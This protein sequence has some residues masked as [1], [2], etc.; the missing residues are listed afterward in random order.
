MATT[1]LNNPFDA[2]PPAT[3]A[4]APVAS[5]NQGLVTNAINNSVAGAS[6]AMPP[7]PQVQ[8]YTPQTSQVDRATETAAGQVDSLLSRDNPLLQRAR[9]I[10]RQNMAQRGLV[11]SSMAQGAGVAAMIDRITPIAQQDALTFSNR[12]MTN[13]EAINQAGLFNAGEAN[14]FSLQRSDQQFTAGQNQAQRDFNSAQAELD[15]AQQVALADKSITAQQALQTAQQNFQAAQAALDRTQQ[16]T[17]QTAQQNFAAAQAALDRAQQIS[18]ADKSIAAN[19]ALQQAQQEF[20]R[21]Q[22]ELDRTLQTNLADKN[23]AAQQ[24]QLQN[25]QTFAAS[26]AALDRQQQTSLQ[27]S[28]V[29]AN[30]ASQAAS[31]AFQASQTSLEIASRNSANASAFISRTIDQ[32]N[33]GINAIIAD[34]NLTPDAKKVAIQNIVD[35]TN[36]SLK[37][38]ATFYNTTVPGYTAPGGAASVLNPGAGAGGGNADTKIR[39]AGAATRQEIAALY[40]EVFGRD[41]DASGANFWYDSGYTPAQIRQAF[42]QSDEYRSKQQGSTGSSSNSTSNNTS[43][44]GTGSNSSTSNNTSTSSTSS[45]TSTSNAGSTGT[46]STTGTSSSQT[47]S[48]AQVASAIQQSMAQGFTLEQSVNAATS[49]YGVPADQAARVADSLQAP[50]NGGGIIGSRIDRDFDSMVER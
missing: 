31:Q 42:L 12:T 47:Y 48:D 1:V 20:Q 37:W 46:A 4:P 11:N 17:L 26:Q 24:A 2:N 5:P 16:V 23:L 27:Q 19:Q 13:M 18:L 50:D 49:V 33:T 36:S 25:Q 43:S 10:A 3:Q 34:G 9:T 6:A 30:Q 28:Q 44:S 29:A 32:A 40:Q 22:A 45:N 35:S 14:K 21:A 41:A 38:A 8:T 7:A 15:R 39:P